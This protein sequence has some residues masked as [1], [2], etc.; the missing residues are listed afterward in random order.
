MLD[1]YSSFEPSTCRMEVWSAAYLQSSETVGNS[2]PIPVVTTICSARLLCW[3]NCIVCAELVMPDVAA[4][5]SHT[6][7]SYV[8]IHVIASETRG[9]VLTGA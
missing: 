5:T 7:Y 9:E 1:Q 6:I 2:L 3:G 8:D 4:V